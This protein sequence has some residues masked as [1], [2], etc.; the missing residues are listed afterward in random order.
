M[1]LL[2]I[3]V[4]VFSL[5]LVY[6]LGSTLVSMLLELWASLRNNREKF[7]KKQ[8]NEKL[9]EDAAKSILDHSMVSGNAKSGTSKISSKVFG[10]VANQQLD[11]DSKQV[12]KSAIGAYGD[13]K[14]TKS[15][16]AA[17][18]RVPDAAAVSAEPTAEAETLSNPETPAANPQ[19][20]PPAGSAAESGNQAALSSWYDDFS[21]EM[22]S[23][24]KKSMRVPSIV[25]A[26]LVVVLL[27][28]DTLR[29]VRSIWENPQD[30]TE[31][32][33]TLSQVDWASLATKEPDPTDPESTNEQIQD[34]L[35]LL[36]KLDTLD[37]K[38]LPLG[39]YSG[40]DLGLVIPASDTSVMIDF[41]RIVA[42]DTGNGI[43]D[44]SFSYRPPTGA[45]LYQSE[46]KVAKMEQNLAAVFPT[47]VPNPNPR[48]LAADGTLKLDF[49]NLFG[50]R[51]VDSLKAEFQGIADAV[52]SFKVSAHQETIRPSFF[53]VVAANLKT[54][55]GSTLVGWLISII[56]I[57]MGAPFW[58]D[59]LKRLS[60]YVTGAGK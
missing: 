29:I 12:I 58:Y 23:Q 53:Q 22:S 47:T 27:N 48:L 5:V 7:L 37:S 30:N 6:F 11:K 45:A 32:L 60:Q 55:S 26:A 2:T 20:A 35:L 8:L 34:I 44:T 15:V 40:E 9:G 16:A 25:V 24:Y 50:Q 51:S 19:T 1:E 49:S 28:L 38:G 4:I 54:V 33:S 56:A 46:A 39:W 42:V 10:Y 14:T 43:S 17:E 59:I 21:K 52:Y 41:N 3:I 57:G 36:S 31:I 13:A 18:A